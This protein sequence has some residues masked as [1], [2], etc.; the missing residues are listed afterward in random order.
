MYGSCMTSISGVP[1]Y[2]SKGL[3]F[4]KKNPNFVKFFSKLTGLSIWTPLEP[5]QEPVYLRLILKKLAKYD[6]L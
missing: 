6:I 5:Y 1:R 2:F 4:E 3:F